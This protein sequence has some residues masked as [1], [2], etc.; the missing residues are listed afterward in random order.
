[1]SP[2]LRTTLALLLVA[3]LFGYR[4]LRDHKP[5]TAPPAATASANAVVASPKSRPLP[6]RKLGSIA[7]APCTLAPQFGPMGVEAQCGTLS[8]A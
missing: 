6:T 3:G 5:A 4:H 2:K 7:F 1:M 8:V